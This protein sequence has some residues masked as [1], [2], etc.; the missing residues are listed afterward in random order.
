[1]IDKERLEQHLNNGKAEYVMC[2]AVHYD[3]GNEYAHQPFNIETGLVIGSWRH[4]SAMQICRFFGIP[5]NRKATA[6]I[7]QGFWTNKNRFLTREEAFDLVNKNG[8]LDNYA[9]KCGHCDAFGRKYCKAYH[10]HDMVQE[11]NVFEQEPCDHYIRNSEIN[12][13]SLLISGTLTSED[14]W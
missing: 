3:D 1:M 8:Q 4:A 9:A 7:T 14:L 13:K 11:Y 5:N 2:A 10:N 12:P 6:I